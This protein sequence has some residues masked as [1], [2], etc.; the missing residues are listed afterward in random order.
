MSSAT[1]MTAEDF[2]RLGLFPFPLKDPI[3]GVKNSGKEPRWRGWQLVAKRSTAK[4]RRAWAFYGWGLGLSLG[5]S[6]LV[7]IDTD[8]EEADRWAEEHL[9]ATPWRTRTS[10][11]HHY[12][13]RLAEGQAAPSN[14]VRVHPL[15]ID[16]RS[17]GGF[18]VSPGSIHWTG[19]IYE[20]EGDWSASILQ[21]PVYD[22]SWFGET[23]R[24][25]AAP[26]PVV[27]PP[28]A[29]LRKVRRAQA[30][31]RTIPPAVQGSGGDFHTYR[32]AC[33]LVSDF[34]LS[35]DE[36]LAALQDWNS[37]CLPPWEPADLEKKVDNALRYS[38]GARGARL[39]E[40]SA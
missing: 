25:K 34:A 19:L 10:K 7:V 38:R 16:R 31:L 22:P 29:D 2:H 15:G 13:Y 4:D 21:L 5:P 24:E 30:Y 8:T 23:A 40:R 14:G 35:K 20:P 28:N 37:T 36:A 18:V 6:R 3:P 27:L 12:F 26:I 33:F 17:D 32:T 9:P 11:G 39:A 1:R